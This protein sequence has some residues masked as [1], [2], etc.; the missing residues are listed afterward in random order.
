MKISHRT[1][2]LLNCIFSGELKGIFINK[3]DQEY[4]DKISQVF[5]EG[6]RYTSSIAK[7][8]IKYI[9]KSFEQSLLQSAG[10]LDQ[11]LHS[12]YEEEGEDLAEHGVFLFSKGRQIVYNYERINY[13]IR[14]IFYCVVGDMLLD[15]YLY[16]QITKDGNTYKYELP[17]STGEY[18]LGYALSLIV[19][20]KYC[21]IETKELPPN[22]KTKGID[23]KYVND[24]KLHITHIDCT[25]FTKLVKSDA[26][27]VRGHFR[28][29]PKKKD[30]EWTKELIWI[31]E[32]QKDGYTA[33]ARKLKEPV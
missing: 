6:W 15:F 22:S 24:S 21:P 14:V 7:D 8:N 5:N 33:P 26:F 17:H 13:K 30:G 11:E 29:Q 1:H 10:K 32:F 16:D 4:I 12:Y 23:C 31:N 20:L 3:D 28:L 9:S 27:K 2:P 25:W 19:F 18:L